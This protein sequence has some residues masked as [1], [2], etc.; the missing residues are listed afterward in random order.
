[1]QVELDISGRIEKNEDTVLGMGGA[2]ERTLL[3]QKR[4][5]S[6]MWNLIEGVESRRGRKRRGRSAQS[7]RLF[8]IMCY[9][10]LIACPSNVTSAVIDKDY[11]GHEG[12][13]KAYILDLMRVHGHDPNRIHISF[14]AV[15]KGAAHSV[16]IAVFR[17]DKVANVV[18]SA[19]DIL[20]F[21]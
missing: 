7:I 1:M 14:G 13:I 11:Y 18:L 16:A 10:Q 4:Q 3:V 17:G 8:A 19:E 5:K 6:F 12:T 15:G 21:Y 2:L 20:E 9:M